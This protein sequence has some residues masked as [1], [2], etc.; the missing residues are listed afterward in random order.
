MSAAYV[1]H[2]CCLGVFFELSE[3][4]ITWLLF[5]QHRCITI[6]KWLILSAARFCS[7]LLSH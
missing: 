7:V 4:P 1:I 5:G 3:K 6:L 2:N